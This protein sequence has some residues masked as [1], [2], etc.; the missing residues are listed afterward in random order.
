MNQNILFSPFP[1]TLVQTLFTG[2]AV[3]FWRSLGKEDKKI[4]VTDDGFH[5]EAHSWPCLPKLKDTTAVLPL[6]LSRIHMVV[7]DLNSL[8]YGIML[9]E[10]VKCHRWI[11]VS[12]NVF[13]IHL[14][15]PSHLWSHISF[16]SH[17]YSKHLT[18]LHS[19][20]FDSI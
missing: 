1:L 11:V 18:W 8:I 6:T 13:H 12:D 10:H 14:K 3:F 15:I 4:G 17:V 7:I 9:S 5:S 19:S 2:I 16:P 20:Y